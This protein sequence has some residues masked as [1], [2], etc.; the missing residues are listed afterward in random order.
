ML[1]EFKLLSF[2]S[3]VKTL[4]SSPSSVVDGVAD[5]RALVPS[6]LLGVTGGCSP[7]VDVARSYGLCQLVGGHPVARWAEAGVPAGV[8]AYSSSMP[9]LSL[10]D[11]LDSE[12]DE[13]R[14]MSALLAP[15]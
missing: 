11:G 5:Q 10:A 6:F 1:L 7:I 4:T 9:A 15:G 13:A 2:K 12:M 8:V 14:R 3:T